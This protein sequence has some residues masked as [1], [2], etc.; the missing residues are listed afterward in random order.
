MQHRSVRIA[1]ATVLIPA[2]CAAGPAQAGQDAAPD[3][4]AL[5]VRIQPD[6]AEWEYRETI[7]GVVKLLNRGDAPIELDAWRLDS[8]TP[9]DPDG[10]I[11]EPFY[12]LG[13]ILSEPGARYT[14]LAPGAERTERF[15]I[16]TDRMH[17]M[18]SGYYLEPGVWD[19]VGPGR[20]AT[21]S[22][23]DMRGARIRVILAEGQYAG[24]RIQT[25]LGAGG[26]L[27]MEREGGIFDVF[28]VGAGERKSMKRPDEYVAGWIWKGSWP[29]FDDG[30]HR[31]AYCASRES[32]VFIELLHGDALALRAVSPPPDLDVGPGGFSAKRF[33]PDGSSL[34][35]ST[36]YVWSF[37]DLATGAERNRA[38]VPMMWSEI[39][40][41]GRWAVSV[42]APLARIVGHRGNDGY[43][44]K[45]I[46]LHDPE[47]IRS[48][49]VGGHGTAPSLHPGHT[50]AYLCDEFSASLVYV[51][52]G[53]EGFSEITTEGPCDFV[54][55]S[56]DGAYVAVASPGWEEA[57]EGGKP[58]VIEVF[59]TED[60][61][62]ACRIEPGEAVRAAL[63][64]NPPRIVCL[65]VRRVTD[66]FGGSG[67]LGEQGSV[68]D[69]T[70]GELI[71]AVDLTPSADALPADDRK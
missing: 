13:C 53:G 63:L 66:P 37:I 46:D 43:E 8:V 58:T 36:N 28:D 5:I 3:E 7:T 23:V 22:D 48:V 50:G 57:E 39:S 11:P 4:A 27:V 12:I 18:E 16:Y 42:E 6:R 26:S 70:T 55:E 56:G 40:P 60:H 20:I 51:P 9:R 47:R 69:A 1:A 41:D 54:G 68:H 2:I 14:Q 64:S 29:V 31:V 25:V 17:T 44:V 30:G 71:K 61:S 19:L 24:P 49:H 52:Y 15:A 33:S 45:A 21:N 34:Y 10:M 38:K 65:P 32:P 67:W 59:R 35:C 62:R